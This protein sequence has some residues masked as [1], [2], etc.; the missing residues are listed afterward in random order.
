[1]A[2]DHEHQADSKPPRTHD[3]SVETFA[4]RRAARQR[5]RDPDR[6]RT[7]ITERARWLRA[8]QWIVATALGFGALYVSWTLWQHDRVLPAL[9]LLGMSVIAILRIFRGSMT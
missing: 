7:K 9:G 8:F 5:A 3:G 1:M 6:E 4:R 2:D